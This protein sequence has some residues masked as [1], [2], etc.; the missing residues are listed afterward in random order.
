MSW[1][2]KA[3]CSAKPLVLVAAA[4]LFGCDVWPRDTFGTTDQV[5]SGGVLYA[6]LSPNPPWTSMTDGH[7]GGVE[8]E[9]V[10]ELAASLDVE[11][12]WTEMNESGLAEALRARQVQIGVGG[13][14]TGMKSSARF[15]RSYVDYKGRKH[16]MAVPH[17][18]SRWLV[19]VESWLHDKGDLVRREL[20]A[21]EAEAAS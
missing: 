16:V 10:E 11:V 5:R 18:E 9:L 19:I 14:H 2:T 21:E 8:V 12:S 13:F 4:F 15:T 3:C 7:P 20:E 1:T 17:G 6:G